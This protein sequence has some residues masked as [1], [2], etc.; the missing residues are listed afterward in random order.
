M[1]MSL[2]FTVGF[3]PEKDQAAAFEKGRGDVA[4]S[5]VNNVYIRYLS[6]FYPIKA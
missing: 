2:L 6:F 1:W 4:A 3:I 5:V